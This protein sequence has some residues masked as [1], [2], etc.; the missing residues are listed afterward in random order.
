MEFRTKLTQEQLANAREQAHAMNEL[1]GYTRSE[2]TRRICKKTPES[3]ALLYYFMQCQD[4]TG[5]TIVAALRLLITRFTLVGEAAEVSRVIIGFASRYR[6]QNAMD[7]TPD[8]VATLASALLILNT[9]IHRTVR[10]GRNRMTF[11]EFETGLYGAMDGGEFPTETLK[12]AYCEVQEEEL[13]HAADDYEA[14]HQDEDTR[15]ITAAKGRS[16]TVLRLFYLG[17]PVGERA[18]SATMNR[19][20]LLAPL[21]AS[22]RR[23][24]W[25]QL[26]V[27]L[28]G[29]MLIFH[30][31]KHQP[32]SAE[33]LNKTSGT[34]PACVML[35]L[36][37]LW[38]TRKG[39]TSS[40]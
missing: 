22:I 29:H 12:R 15:T 38:I 34:R 4:F 33:D 39:T 28:H 14:R 19:K 35:S 21:G 20:E 3:Q 31:P 1:Q 17:E 25:R 36:G 40:A 18:L 30:L 23:H 24:R 8:A 10:G 9:D 26:H 32:V 13:V 27:A 6:E 7:C 2:V 16:D 5:M 11:K 37:W